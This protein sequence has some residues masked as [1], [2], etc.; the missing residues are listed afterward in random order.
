[1]RQLARKFESRTYFISTL[2]QFQEDSVTS[3][4]EMTSRNIETLNLSER[5]GMSLKFNFHCALLLL[6]LFTGKWNSFILRHT[7]KLRPLSGQTPPLFGG[8]RGGGSEVPLK[9]PI[10][11]I[12]K[13]YLR[14]VVFRMFPAHQKNLSVKH[15]IYDN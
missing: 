14:L 2:A 6:M 4:A 15:L 3:N 7:R 10:F 11:E 13:R 9:S 12:M 5:W 8:F 1:M